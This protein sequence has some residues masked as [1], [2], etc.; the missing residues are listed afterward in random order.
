MNV[1]GNV[2]A[3][4]VLF[5]R[6]AGLGAAM[7]AAYDGLRI[8]RKGIAH[9]KQW[10]DRED[11]IFW[12]CAGLLFF[13]FLICHYQGKLRF[14]EIAAVCLG[15]WVY[16]HTASPAVVAVGG[17]GFAAVTGLCRKC[18][19]RLCRLIKWLKNEGKR[20]KLQLCCL[21]AKGRKDKKRER[22]KNG[23]NRRK[24]T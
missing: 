16:Q 8:F 2:T 5:L 17:R 15:A 7:G 23:K 12:I 3:E 1:A 4:T 19:I 9:K 6:T 10:I 18:R 21:W 22:T 14:F 13:E 20:V 11:L 24:K